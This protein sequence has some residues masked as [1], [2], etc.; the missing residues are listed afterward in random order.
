MCDGVKRK[1]RGG[2][3]GRIAVRETNGSP[4]KW[5]FPTHATLR[6]KRIDT[7]PR[8]RFCFP[9]TPFFRGATATR[10]RSV[11]AVSRER[12][13]KNPKTQRTFRKTVIV[14]PVVLSSRSHNNRRRRRRP[15]VTMYKRPVVGVSFPRIEA[16][17][18][19]SLLPS[20]LDTGS[21]PF[22][23]RRLLFEK[24]YV[25]TYYYIV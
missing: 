1:R 18:H 3:N 8:L 6:R 13:P 24:R 16:W 17:H 7:A 14:V 4:A 2:W 25:Y 15:A 21:I 20:S 5:P 23:L 12:E 11:G 22:T 19:L 10:R 9:P